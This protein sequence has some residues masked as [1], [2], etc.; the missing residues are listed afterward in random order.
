MAIAYEENAQMLYALAKEH[1]KLEQIFQEMQLFKDGVGG[2]M[3]FIQMM[4][5]ENVSN[6]RKAALITEIA[7]FFQEETQQFFQFF[8]REAQFEYIY[9]AVQ[10]FERLY[11]AHHLMITSAIPLTENQINA[12]V[13]K[14]SLKMG[15]DM[16]TFEAIVDET[17]LGGVKIQTS[18]FVID[19]TIASSLQAFSNLK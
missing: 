16:D 14:V 12:I 2:E 11:K 13:Q 10:S 18:D 5:R 9:R 1:N 3:P 4:T 7:Q 6:S 8:V 17:V 15:R 19:A